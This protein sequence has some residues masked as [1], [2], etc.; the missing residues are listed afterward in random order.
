MKTFYSAEDIENLGEGMYNLDLTDTD[1]CISNFQQAIVDG[2]LDE[3]DSSQFVTEEGGTMDNIVKTNIYLVDNAHY[4][5]F[6][7]IN[8]PGDFAFAVSHPN[9]GLSTLLSL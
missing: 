8:G 2:T 7:D 1:G 5:A 4:Q 9:R 6:R 3:L